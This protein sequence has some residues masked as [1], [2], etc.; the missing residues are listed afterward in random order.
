MYQEREPIFY[1]LTMY[2]EK[3]P[4]PP[5]P[6]GSAEGIL[7]G[8]Y[9]LRGRDGEEGQEKQRVQLLGSGPLVREALRAQELLADGFGIG[10]EVWS[11]TSYSELRKE[12]LAADRW[13]LLHPGEEEPRRSYVERCLG[14][15]AAGGP[16]VAVSDY[17]RLVPEQIARWLPGRLTALGTDGFG[18]SDTRAALR[19]HFEVDAEHVALAAL[20]ALCRQGQVEAARVREAMKRWEIDPERQVEP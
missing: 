3:Y 16:V 4:Q 14:S 8:M 18:R 7:R 6:D 12:A 19:R 5:M 17:V 13:N 1:Y 11:V 2:N 9:R 10:S 20:A 15:A